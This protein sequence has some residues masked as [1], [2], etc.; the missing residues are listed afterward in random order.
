MYSII[1]RIKRQAVFGDF[2]VNNSLLPKTIII[3]NSTK[4]RTF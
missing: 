3:L 1:K 4:K 2:S